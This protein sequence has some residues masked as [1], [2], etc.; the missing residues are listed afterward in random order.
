[1]DI[2]LRGT[3]QYVAGNAVTLRGTQTAMT[4]KTDRP[5]AVLVRVGQ[6]R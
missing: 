5:A 6:S 1:M 4:W 3:E 2:N